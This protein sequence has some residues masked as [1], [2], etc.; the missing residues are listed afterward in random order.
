MFCR[1]GDYEHWRGVRLRLLL[2]QEEGQKRGVQKERSTKCRQDQKSRCLRWVW[3]KE[4]MWMS[5]CGSAGQLTSG[6]HYKRKAP[7]G[8]ADLSSKYKGV[9]VVP[10]RS[11]SYKARGDTQ[12]YDPQ[13]LCM[14]V[15]HSCT[16][17]ITR[18]Y[19]I[20]TYRSF[21]VTSQFGL[22]EVFTV[23]GQG[24]SQAAEKTVTVTLLW[25][26]V[27]FE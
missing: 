12:E 21:H 20:L 7:W 17:F 27:K 11:E 6:L 26:E 15:A 18:K 2:N 16:Q 5:V 3:E 8:S 14:G 1:R 22:N 10:A 25:L 13:K 23:S 24:E 9:V 19:V 4:S